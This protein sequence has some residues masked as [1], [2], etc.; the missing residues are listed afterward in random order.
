MVE[1]R[2]P[3]GTTKSRPMQALSAVEEVGSIDDQLAAG[4]FGRARDL[5][6][7]ITFEKLK[8]TLHEVIYSMEAAQVDFY[9]YQFK[10]VIKFIDSPTERLVIADEV[11]LGKTIESLL[12]WMELVARRQARRL[13]IVCPKLLTTKWQTELRTKFM[14]DATIVGHSEV[15]RTLEEL[16]DR[17]PGH[18]CVLIASYSA[19]RPPKAE[20]SALDQPPLSDSELSPKTRLLQELRQWAQEFEPFD[21]V[22][23]DEAHYMRNPAT[24]SFRLGESLASAA[25]AVLCV[26]A[27][28]VNNKNTDLHSLLRLIDPDFFQTQGTFEALLE[29]NRPTVQAGNALSR[30]PP[31][32]ESA[33]T[34][35]QGMRASRYIGESPLLAE[36][37][38]LIDQI[39]TGS[40]KALARAQA[41]VEKLNLLGAYVTR[42]RRVQVK[43]Q[44]PLREPQAL[45]VRYSPEER[46]LYDAILGLVRRK[47]RADKRP[48]HVFHVMGL[49]L[50][51][52]S[53]L[54]AIAAE[55]RAGRLGDPGEILAE[56]LGENVVDEGDGPV[57]EPALGV[58]E[59]PKILDYDFERNDSKY[60]ELRR[61]LLEQI[62]ND[63]VVLFSFYHA[64]LRY[65]VR[66]L[67]EDGIAVALIHGKMPNEERLAEIEKVRESA[68]R[69]VLLSSEVG[70]EGLDLQFCRVVVNYDLPWN[71]M[72]VEQRI[73]RIDRVGQEAKRLVVVNFKVADTIEERLF[74]RLHTK[75]LT[76]ANS[77]GDLEEVIGREVQRLTVQ[78]LGQELSPDEERRLMDQASQVIEQQMIQMQAL[79]E[80]GDALLSLS[81][82]LQRKL[83]EDRDRGRFIQPEELE[84][85]VR[86]F[87][88][89]EFQ[90]CELAFDA[91]A[92]GCITLRLTS[93]AAQSLSQFVGNDQTLLAQPFRKREFSLSFRREVVMHLEPAVRRRVA[94]ANHMSPLV[95][96]ITKVTG[97][98]PS[99]FHPVSAI[100]L[101]TAIVPEGTY[102]YRVERWRLKGMAAREQLA[103]GAK[104]LNGAAELDS[105]VA[106]SVVQEILRGGQNWEY[107]D[108][109]QTAVREANVRLE[110]DM[111]AGF[112][113]AVTSFDN[114][115]TTASQIRTE[116]VN[117]VFER[118]IAFDEQRLRTLRVGGKS[119]KIIRAT[120]GRLRTAHEAREARLAALKKGVHIDV[121]RELV[122]AGVVRVRSAEGRP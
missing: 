59:L 113:S 111:A 74:D 103:Y 75:L 71:P 41:L 40:R 36:L 30:I 108:C 100:E 63:K 99:T 98:V 5:Q 76:F 20:L 33:S 7:L 121:E 81:D 118:R 22:V 87:F 32:V 43:E 12:I 88:E 6:R 57:D 56:A 77:L 9:P 58:E 27:T 25:E 79:E 55:I 18:G 4:R 122:A 66:R 115:N 38:P 34:A 117:A 107:P 67:S 26:S 52:A 112:D 73:G 60:R 95:R 17:G 104:P 28:P 96:W 72:R 119:D 102:G 80:S 8:G 53:C 23:F 10:P 47:C 19:L 14:I 97:S 35:L 83:E 45:L 1:L 90:G 70:S 24:A 50:R 93:E 54:P 116:R 91:P 39:A 82:Y 64:S 37:E 92:P 49:Q 44:R 42:T 3:D 101:Q 31:D 106:E 2:Y 21:L 78:L 85:Y 86:D 61:L 48:F 68:S 15:A 84:S 110:R 46:Q 94:F 114:D 62:P 29:A 120:E 105:A 13:L 65:L 51:A 16:R 109:S 89:R 69:M 11:G